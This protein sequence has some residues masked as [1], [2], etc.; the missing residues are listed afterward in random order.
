MAVPLPQ[1]THLS[2]EAANVSAVAL[3]CLDHFDHGN[4]ILLRKLEIALIMR[5]HGHDRSGAVAHHDVVG[6]P[7]GD[8]LAVDRIGRGAAGED[9]ALF[10]RQVGALEVG[11]RGARLAIRFDGVLLLRGHDLVDERMLGR[12]DHV[13][14][15]EE[16]VGPRR[17]DGDLLTSDG[18]IHLRSLAS[19]DPV[20]LEQLDALGPVEAVEFVDEALGVG[21]DA[22]H[23]LLERTALDGV[24]FRSPF[25]D[26]LVREHGAEIG[27]PVHGCLG[28]V[29]E[30]FRVDLVTAPGL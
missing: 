17:E 16:G 12:E 15:A 28:D 20:F 22:Q 9:A 2:C 10:L 4:P 30:A 18:E 25:L 14:R 1:N 6:D 7:H 8:L 26:F 21:G 29:G 3:G 23:P 27:T 11:L 24:A 5:R 19:S 13:G